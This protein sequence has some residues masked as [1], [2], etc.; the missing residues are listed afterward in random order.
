MHFH[1]SLP[2]LFTLQQNDAPVASARAKGGARPGLTGA[3]DAPALSNIFQEA[4]QDAQDAGFLQRAC[5]VMMIQAGMRTDD[6]ASVFGKSPRSIERWLL[7]YEV[8]GV[9]GLRDG[10]R[11]GR[12]PKLGH[13]CSQALTREL[14][15]PPRASGYARTSWDGPLLAS[16][17]QARYG[18]SLSTRQCQRLLRIAHSAGSTVSA[19]GLARK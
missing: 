5:C 19:T 1:P 3:A 9:D 8:L 17:L 12:Q 16:H 13:T 18:V 6:V 14:S 7:R 4:T 2:K 10:H 11:S 15:L